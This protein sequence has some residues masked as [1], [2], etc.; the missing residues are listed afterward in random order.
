MPK[1]YL[2]DSVG[3][4]LRAAR[5]ATGLNQP[6][7][8]ERTGIPQPNISAYERGAREPNLANLSRL[9]AALHHTFVLDRHGPRFV[10]PAEMQLPRRS[11]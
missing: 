11:G 9:V 7:L 3:A 5:K 4:S 2:G 1:A 6:E 10:K 8:A